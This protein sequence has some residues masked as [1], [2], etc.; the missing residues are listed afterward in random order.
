MAASLKRMCRKNTSSVDYTQLNSF[1]SAVM[2]DGLFKRRFSK[3]YILEQIIER[4]KTLQVPCI[5]AYFSQITLLDIL[6]H[7]I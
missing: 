3:F 5:F 1:S 2:Y 6:E 7:L 4:R